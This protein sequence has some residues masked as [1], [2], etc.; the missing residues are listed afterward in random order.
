LFGRQSKNG[1]DM[2]PDT[3]LSA[4]ALR[5]FFTPW[6]YAPLAMKWDGRFVSIQPVAKGHQPPVAWAARAARFAVA[7]HQ[8]GIPATR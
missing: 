4:L 8:I 7:L 5:R 6:R 2:R 3:E 1:Y